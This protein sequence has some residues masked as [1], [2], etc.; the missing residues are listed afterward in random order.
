MRSH[1]SS[2]TSRVHRTL[3]L[4]LALGLACGVAALATLPGTAARA[5]GVALRTSGYTHVI[6][7][8]MENLGYSSATTYSGYQT[9]A[10]RYASASNSYAAA[11][12]SLPNYLD[13]TAGTTFGVSSD[14]TSCYQTSNNLGAQLSAKRVTWDDFS[15]GVPGPCFLGAST[16][17]GYAGKHNPFRYY[18][19]IRKNRSLCRHLL[20]LTS[21][22]TD[23]RRVKSMPRFSFV[24]PNLC[25]D[26]H[27]CSPSVAFS[28]LQSFVKSVTA[29]SA[30]KQHGLLVVTWDEGADS[31]TSTVLP[32]DQIHGNGGGG[33]VATLLIAPGVRAG[34]VVT[35]PMT[36]ESLLAS[37]ES[38]FHLAM[39]RGAA[40]WSAHTLVIP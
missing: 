31:D 2:G 26:G 33:H 35:A 29:S 36:H 16:G 5:S 1:P 32:N 17:S 4:P 23:L 15:E 24:T 39:L 34:T 37:I 25:H 40:K 6:E 21:L 3:R 14:C 20:P 11:H 28:W 19:D 38:N 30:W 27:D 7:V 18:T 13:L 8:V 9:L 22:M 10:H 12:P